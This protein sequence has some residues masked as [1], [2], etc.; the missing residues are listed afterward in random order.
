MKNKPNRTIINFAAFVMCCLFASLVNAQESASAEE[1]AKL[2]AEQKQSL[3]EVE[4]NR[5]ATEA[6]AQQVRDALDAQEKR[7]SQ[8]EEE[9]ETLCKEQ[10]VLK[11]GSYDDCIGDQ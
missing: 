11:P 7:M 9:Y 10:E 6:Q 2:L 8:L 5:D 4:A 3:A 1:L